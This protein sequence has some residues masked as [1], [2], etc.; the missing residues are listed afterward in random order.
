MSQADM[1]EVD[2]D[3]FLALW[4]NA[5]KINPTSLKSWLGCVAR[6]AAKNKLR[7]L[8]QDLPLEDDVILIVSD[9]P[10]QQLVDGERKRLVQEA[11][12]AMDWPDREIFLR[13]YYYCQSVADI[14]AEMERNPATIKTRLRR[15]R[16]K[17]RAV[18]ENKWSEE[19]GTCDAIQNF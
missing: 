1:E 12:L 15:G 10:E 19:G 5:A 7:S 4:N 8:H 18:L 16:E 17:L 14:A 11:V 6:N 13:H 2:A 9:T 3:V